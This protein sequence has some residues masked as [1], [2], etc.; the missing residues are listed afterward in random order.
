MVGLVIHHT[1]LDISGGGGGGR[2]LK[3][4]MVQDTLEQIEMVKVL[5]KEAH[6]L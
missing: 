1:L 2:D 6:D 3:P 4:T 5:L